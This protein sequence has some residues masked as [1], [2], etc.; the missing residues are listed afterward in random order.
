MNRQLPL[1]ALLCVSAQLYAAD[2]QVY[3]WT[4]A[5][6]VVH[7]T[8]APPPKETLNVQTVRVSGGDRPRAVALDNS[9]A[10]ATTAPKDA[11][12]TNPPPANTA[13]TP[14]NRTK[15]CQSARGNLEMLQSKFPVSI[16]G[17]DGKPQQ[18][19]DKGRQDQ[20]TSA[21]AQVA[22]YCQ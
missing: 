11:S 17:A 15:L 10:N 4:D 22:Q 12:A 21:N 20:I 2:S 18:L 13:D 8:D 19:D 5:A 1:L 9:D 14:D 7:Y 6:G 3:K 16:A